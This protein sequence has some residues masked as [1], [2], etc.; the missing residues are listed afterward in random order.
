MRPCS[1]HWVTSEH[2]N[3]RARAPWR[4]RQCTRCWEHTMCSPSSYVGWTDF[5]ACVSS[6][7]QRRRSL[8]VDRRARAAASCA[9]WPRRRDGSTRRASRCT[10]CY[11]TRH[12]AAAAGRASAGAAAVAAVAAAVAGAVAA[13]V[14][15]AGAAAAAGPAATPAGSE[16]AAAAATTAEPAVTTGAAAAVRPRAARGAV[17]AHAGVRLAAAVVGRGPGCGRRDASVG[18]RHA[19][20][21][22]RRRRAAAGAAAAE[23]AALPVGRRAQPRRADIGERGDHRHADRPAAAHART[24]C[25]W[26]RGTRAGGAR[27]ARRR[28][29]RRRR[30]V[31][32]GEAEAAG[33]GANAALR[34]DRRRGAEAAEGLFGR[35]VARAAGAAARLH[36]LAQ[37]G[38][39]R[40][41]RRRRLAA[42]RGDRPRPVPG[43][44][45]PARRATRWVTRRPR[46]SSS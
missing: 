29:R 22:G 31:P 11:P 25:A 38:R 16:A 15:A 28:S 34:L 6:A 17:A 33:P 42:A 39:H 36:R 19:A 24:A 26:R 9:R 41:H 30:Q 2:R 3:E 23:I 5:D 1:I 35:R 12:S 14:A 43:V 40:R 8:P 32:A 13:A 37:G 45:A 20:P 4:P 44:L 18:V 27:G 46:P 7:D 21:R 10:R